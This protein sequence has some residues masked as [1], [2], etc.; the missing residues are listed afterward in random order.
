MLIFYGSNGRNEIKRNELIKARKLC[1]IFR[2]IYEQ[3]SS[4]DG[5]EFEINYSNSYPTELDLAKENTNKQNFKLAFDKRDL[6]TYSIF[7]MPHMSSNT[8]SNTV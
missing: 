5:G 1:N 3:N 8:P 6:F 7:R 2:F 4:N